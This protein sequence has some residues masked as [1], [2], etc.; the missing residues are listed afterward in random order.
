MTS[1]G[2]PQQQQHPPPSP[3]TDLRTRV[4]EIL[5]TVANGCL[6]ELGY[7]PGLR[8]ELARARSDNGKL[9]ADNRALAQQVALLTDRCAFLA[10]THGQPDQLAQL[11]ELRR[12]V[13]DLRE[14]RGALQ[15]LADHHSAAHDAIRRTA[16]RTEDKFARLY[17]MAVTA[18]IIPDGR[19]HPAQHPAGAG[20]HGPAAAAGQQIVGPVQ[21]H[22]NML[23][24]PP[25]QTG[26]TSQA[27]R[28][29]AQ[30]SAQHT[31]RTSQSSSSQ[32]PQVPSQSSSTSQTLRV[33]SQSSTSRSTKSSQP[34][35]SSQHLQSTSTSQTHN[36]LS[37]SNISHTPRV[38]SQSNSTS[39]APRVPSQPHSTSQT[40]RVPTPS[41][42]SHST[43]PSQPGPSSQHTKHPPPPL[44]FLSNNTLQVPQPPHAA[45]DSRPSRRVSYPSTTSR[46]E[47]M[48]PPPA[49]PLSASASATTFPRMGPAPVSLPTAGLLA[50]LGMET[51]ALPPRRR[52]L[53][54][55]GWAPPNASG[56]QDVIDLT[57]DDE[58]RGAQTQ[59]LQPSAV[60]GSADRS[61]AASPASASSAEVPLAAV[62]GPPLSPGVQ[63]LQAAS[64]ASSADVPLSAV[65][66][67]RSVHDEPPL[68][69]ASSADVP[70]SASLPLP[71]PAHTHAMAVSPVEDALKRVRTLSMEPHAASPK[72]ARFADPPST[73]PTAAAS[74][75]AEMEMEMEAAGMD[76]DAEIEPPASTVPDGEAGEALTSEE[77][78]AESMFA[79]DDDQPGHFTC[80][81]CELRF[82]EGLSDAPEV[83]VHPRMDVL[84]AH[85]KD[86][87]PTVWDSLRHTRPSDV[88]SV[89]GSPED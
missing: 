41:S 67:R 38:P 11:D 35:S 83:Y 50:P 82:E 61:A 26:L 65:H 5:S 24:R 64:P 23:S 46:T 10:G 29:S 77:D 89:P 39:Q 18:G 70:L 60:R 79:E 51:F 69:P 88:D 58:G 86:E 62:H 59:T 27:A 66:A 85:C 73:E 49:R 81:L 3:I 68:S 44:L 31:R 48:A 21:V 20:G 52:E 7:Y 55:A 16:A 87:H 19:T 17:Q 30:S 57:S 71:P 25:S 45:P 36:V 9:Y 75:D 47:G 43:K 56:S 28:S 13:R 80:T 15:A 54:P 22:P 37:L 78:C 63:A 42:T 8:E 6:S 33:P 34:S 32:T 76:V 14:E 72:R 1:N 12:T 53:R 4:V 84:I 2:P 40:L 74:P